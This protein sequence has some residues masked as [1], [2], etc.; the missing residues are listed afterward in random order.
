VRDRHVWPAA[1]RECE[2]AKG[3]G[4][5]VRPCHLP[6]M[7]GRGCAA[8]TL[9][10]MCRART[11][12]RKAA[13]RVRGHESKHASRRWPERRASLRHVCANAPPPPLPHAAL[14][15]DADRPVLWDA[16][17]RLAPRAAPT[18]HSPATARVRV[19]AALMRATADR[20]AAG[21]ATR[22]AGGVARARTGVAPAEGRDVDGADVARRVEGSIVGLVF[23]CRAS[24]YDNR[25]CDKARRSGVVWCDVVFG[26]VFL[27]AHFR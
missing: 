6:A 22:P 26:A 12:A 3:A 11:R 9:A 23:F 17:T 1:L 5:L 18:Q 14:A 27:F 13:R 8:H 19:G 4:R 15:L 24:R 7:A 21:D 20:S 10:L 25:G 2:A 16:G